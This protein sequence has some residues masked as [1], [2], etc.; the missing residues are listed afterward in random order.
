MKNIHLLPTEKPSRLHYYSVLNFGVSKEN[1][2][3]KQGRH[4]YITSDEKIKEGDWVYYSG[5]QLDFPIGIYKTLDN[6][7]E[8][9]SVPS[10]GGIGIRHRISEEL[11]ENGKKKIRG[12]YLKIG[13]NIFQGEHL[14]KI[15]LTTDQDLIAD[16]VQAIDNEFLEWFVENSTCE[17]VEVEETFPSLCCVSIKKEGKTKMNSACMERNRCLFYV[18]I[19][20]KEKSCTQNVVDEA[21]KIVSKDVRQPK[22]VRDGLVTEQKQETLEDKIQMLISEWQQRQD[23]YEDIARTAKNEHT[24]RKFTYKAVATRDCWKELLKVIEQNKK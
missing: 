2:N 11:M 3:W 18:I 23:N 17:F 4:I 15:I 12:A 8:K 7:K 19:I 10:V 22:C 9:M 14:K 13:Y 1:L 24:D 20:P 6:V 21:M 16:G 5:Q